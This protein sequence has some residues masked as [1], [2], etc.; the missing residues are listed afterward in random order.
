MEHCHISVGSVCNHDSRFTDPAVPVSLLCH[1]GKVHNE[2][3]EL[4]NLGFRKK[5]SCNMMGSLCKWV[6]R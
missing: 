3:G 6:L 2:S 4:D 1:M 5:G